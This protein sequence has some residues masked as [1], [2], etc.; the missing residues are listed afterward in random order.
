MEVCVSGVQHWK[1]GSEACEWFVA[2]V[3]RV[4]EDV[5]LMGCATLTCEPTALLRRHELVEQCER[6]DADQDQLHAVDA[7][8]V[9]WG[10]HRIGHFGRRVDVKPIP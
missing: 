8:R 10:G 3:E 6:G 2:L 4:R 5:E 7:H 1:C 9:G